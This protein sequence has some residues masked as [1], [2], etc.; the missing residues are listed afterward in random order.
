MTLGTYRVHVAVGLSIVMTLM[1][2][3]QYPTVVTIF[4]DGGQLTNMDVEDFV[5]K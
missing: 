4:F 5:V 3:I 1:G 2:T